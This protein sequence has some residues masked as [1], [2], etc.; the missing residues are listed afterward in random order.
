MYMY[1]RFYILVL[2]VL[3]LASCSKEA[4]VRGVDVQFNAAI[5]PEMTVL[6]KGGDSQP[7]PVIA[8]HAVLQAWR[9]GVMAAQAEQSIGSG[10]TQI[11]FSGV[12]LAC[13]ATY[14]IY[15][16]VDCEGYYNTSDLRSVSV[17][18]DKLFDGKTA[19]FDAFCHFGAVTCG[20]NDEVH[21]VTLTRPFAKVSFSAAV[22]QDVTISYKAP[23]TLDLKTGAVSGEKTVNYTATHDGSGVTAFDYVFATEEVSQLSYTFKLG[24]EEAKT[25]SVPVKR[26]TK[27][28]II[29]NITN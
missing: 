28:N 15:V 7:E 20:Q 12:K 4:T 24:S 14:L 3:S 25:T 6:V 18:E 11:S 21:Q 16:W 5:S 8:N 19:E 27:T 17:K 29:Y 1:K 23:T 13:G 10:T 26:N 2:I 9:D 22:E